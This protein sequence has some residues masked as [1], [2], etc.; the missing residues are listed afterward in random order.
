MKIY[1][2]GAHGVGKST[3][4]RHVSKKHQLPMICEAARQILAEQELQ[5]D[6]LRYDL[7]VVDSYQKQVFERQL[8]EESKQ[9]SFV[10]DRSLIDCLGYS[11]QH[12]R[13]LPKL[14]ASPLLTTYIAN[15]RSSGSI[16]FF[17]RPSRATLHAQ[18][19][20]VREELDWDGIISIDSMIKF[21]LEMYN[22]NYISINSDSMQ[23]RIRLIS[24]VLQLIY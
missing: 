9:E 19:D 18:A 24:S 23:E 12:S 16:L 10:A 6:V 2:S 17:V 21:L 22:I 3:L 13:I 20:G 11:A 7:D 15:L 5:I 1:F 8:S 14:L 4:A